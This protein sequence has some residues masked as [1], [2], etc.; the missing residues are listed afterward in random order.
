M[1]EKFETV[2]DWPLVMLNS[3]TIIKA[4]EV[5]LGKP[6]DKAE[7]WPHR[8]FLTLENP[9]QVIADARDPKEVCLIGPRIYVPLTSGDYWTD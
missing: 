8:N 3:G 5:Y 6:S 2:K 4:R 7:V 1:A 9:Y